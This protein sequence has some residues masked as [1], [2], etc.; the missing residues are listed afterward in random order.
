MNRIL[1]LILLILLLISVILYLNFKKSRYI[2]SYYKN[3]NKIK[4]IEIINNIK[5]DSSKTIPKVIY[6]LYKGNKGDEIPE[7]IKNNIEHL[8]NISPKWKHILLRDD[9]IEEFILEHYGNDILNIYNMINPRYG[10]ARADF[11][12][13]LLMY[14]KGGVYLDIKST[15]LH[16]LDVI[17]KDNTHYILSHWGKGGNYWRKLLNNKYGEFQQ[18]HIITPPGHYFL[19]EVIKQVIINIL[20]YSINDGV[21]KKGVLNLTGPIAYSIVIL[22]LIKDNDNEDYII[23]RDNKNI[24]L[25]Y[26]IYNNTITH[27]KKLFKTH[28][29]KL[30]EPIV[31]NN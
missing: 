11:F 9:E 3:T 5:T 12:R 14:V 20:S 24:G 16:N 4:A 27:E 10:A 26:T 23:F 30:K 2:Y 25:I 18:W 29:S 19:K 22:K 21:G 13:Y 1:I 7:D 31:I 8:K 15:V 28:Y 6:Q 17:I